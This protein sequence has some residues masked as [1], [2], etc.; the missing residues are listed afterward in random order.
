MSVSVDAA[1]LFISSSP[2][3]L[4][5]LAR[6]A[7]H[8]FLFPSVRRWFHLNATP[9]TVLRTAQV[10]RVE[11]KKGKEQVDADTHFPFQNRVDLRCQRR[12]GSRRGDDVLFGTLTSSVTI[13]ALVTVALRLIRETAATKG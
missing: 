5:L 2:F 6:H 7:C 8:T 1:T 9:T 4:N 11:K 13:T 3:D 10:I 12:I